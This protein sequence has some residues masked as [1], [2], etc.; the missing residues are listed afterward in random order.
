N[1]DVAMPEPGPG[2]VRVKLEGSGVCASN[3]AVWEGA[4][5][6]EYPLSPGAPGH[7]GWG[8]IDALGSGVTGLEIG[9]RVAGLSGRAFAGYDIA[10]ADQLVPLPAIL[11][12]QPF[13][14]EPLG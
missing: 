9:M 2:Q 12:D 11:Q 4:P 3:L 6:F 10:E 5:W 8:E 7:E 1:R 13:P 14:G